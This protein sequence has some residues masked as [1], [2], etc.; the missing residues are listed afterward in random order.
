MMYRNGAIRRSATF[1]RTH[2]ACDLWRPVLYLLFQFSSHR[3]V[4]SVYF[5]IYNRATTTERPSRAEA[6]RTTLAAVTAT[7]AT[8][9]DAEIENYRK[10]PVP[11]R[12][13]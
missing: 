1:I 2:S 13:C 8:I 9:A 5:C 10:R 4:N 11:S 6:I 12:R 7:A 3:H